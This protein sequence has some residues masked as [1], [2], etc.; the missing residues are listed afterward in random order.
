M[1]LQWLWISPDKLLFDKSRFIRL[2]TLLMNGGMLPFR[3]FPDKSRIS[4]CDI[5]WPNSKGIGLESLLFF[6]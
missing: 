5:S 4:Y 2:V 1:L 6:K 3:K